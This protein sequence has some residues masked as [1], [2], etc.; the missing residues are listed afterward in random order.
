MALQK[1]IREYDRNIRDTSDKS[2]IVLSSLDVRKELASAFEKDNMY[3]LNET[4]DPIELLDCLLKA[5]HTYLADKNCKSIFMYDPPPCIKKCYVHELFEMTLSEI[6]SC[7]KCL[8]SQ[9][10]I[11]KYDSNLFHFVLY[12]KEILRYCKVNNLSLDKI[13][14][15]MLFYSQQIRVSYITLSINTIIGSRIIEMR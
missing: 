5:Y 11:I 10:K 7:L 8:P 9:P 15:N 3:R 13:K 2:N 6:S 12:T 1:I 14:E 4:G